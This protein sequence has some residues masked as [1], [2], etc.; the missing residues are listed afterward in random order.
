[1]FALLPF[2][3]FSL[4]V[5]FFLVVPLFFSLFCT[6]VVHVFFFRAIC[7]TEKVHEVAV[8]EDPSHPSLET[9]GPARQRGRW[10][11]GGRRLQRL[12]GT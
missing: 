10:G 2:H 12:H 6:V 5:F 4:L 3:T 7:S 11:R 9:E 8:A 1:M